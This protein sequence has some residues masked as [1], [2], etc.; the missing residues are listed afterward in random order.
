MSKKF[1]NEIVSQFNN[2]INRKNTY[3]SN[4]NTNINL[5]LDKLSRLSINQ[6]TDIT[7]QIDIQNEQIEFQLQS[8]NSEQTNEVKS[9]YQNIEI[10]KLQQQNLYLYSF[11]YILVFILKIVMFFYSNLSI[12]IKIIIF[13]LLI[14]FPFIIYYLELFLFM[15]YKYSVN[16]FS[17]TPFSSVYV[18]KY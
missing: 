3:Q 14:S 9:Q 6:I 1:L 12:F 10:D 15:I 16:F 4:I 11:F 5:S 18:T 2:Y 8:N 13:G 7:R 17:S